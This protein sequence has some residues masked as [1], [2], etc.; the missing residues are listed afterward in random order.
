MHF[1]FMPVH[2][3]NNNEYKHISKLSKTYFHTYIATITSINITNLS[4]IS[5]RYPQS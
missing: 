3:Y 4:S 5:D 2:I 1:C